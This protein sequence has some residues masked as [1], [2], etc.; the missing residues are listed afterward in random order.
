MMMGVFA[1]ILAFLGLSASVYDNW[2]LGIKLSVILYM[3]S[4]AIGLGGTMPLYCSEII[5]AVGVGMGVAL[6][7]LSSG[8]IAYIVPQT[9][10]TIGIQTFIYI[11]VVCNLF[12]LTFVYFA[13]PETK[14]VDLT[15][16]TSI[17]EKK[18]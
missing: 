6:Q 8:I 13:C 17:F 16:V 10:D 18:K 5:P 1:Q 9:I 15:E 4:F 2:Q 12:S 14:G 3:L 7:W 11:F